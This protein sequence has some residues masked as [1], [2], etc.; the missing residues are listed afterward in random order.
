[1]KLAWKVQPLSFWER[2]GWL[3]ALLASILTVA[4]IVY[5]YI[6]PNRFARELAVSF[7]PDYADLDDQT[8]M[9]LKQWRDVRIGFYRDA[10]A[11]FHPD[12]KIS[13]KTK[14]ALAVLHAGRNRSAIAKPTPGHSLYRE[15]SDGEWEPVSI[16]TGRRIGNG[17]VYRIGDHG[18]HFR[19][20]ARLS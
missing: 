11:F 5:G 16:E 8:P 19:I 18:P 14:G 17:E 1:L 3:I 13:G 4:V 2:W 6:K 20:S 12:Y 10:R 15:T 7:T 9:P